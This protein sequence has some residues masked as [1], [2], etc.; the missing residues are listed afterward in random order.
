LWWLVDKISCRE[1]SDKKN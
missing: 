1:R